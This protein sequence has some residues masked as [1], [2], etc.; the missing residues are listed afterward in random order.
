[1]SI[2]FVIQ[3]LLSALHERHEEWLIRNKFPVPAPVVV[4]IYDI[5]I[6]TLSY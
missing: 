1:M 2:L 6:Y 4:S 5:F 3:E